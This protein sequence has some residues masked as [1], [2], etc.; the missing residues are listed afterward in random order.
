VATQDQAIR[1]YMGDEKKKKNDVKRDVALLQKEKLMYGQL[2]E[3]IDMCFVAGLAFFF[4]FLF[5]SSS[6]FHFT[7]TLSVLLFLFLFL[8]PFS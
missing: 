8:F 4:F 2:D 5:F 1:I 3:I 6:S 7:F